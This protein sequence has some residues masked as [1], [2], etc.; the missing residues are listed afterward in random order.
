MQVPDRPWFDRQGTLLFE[1]LLQQSRLYM[2]YGSGG[3]T[4]LAAHLGENFIS[5][6]SDIGFSRAVTDRIGAS[7]GAGDIIAVNIG[8]TE[9]GVRRFSPGRRATGWNCG[10]AMSAPP[11]CGCRRAWRQTSF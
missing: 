8:T 4:V 7:K 6:E 5:V 10:N 1:E 9:P 2:E 11:G 3:S